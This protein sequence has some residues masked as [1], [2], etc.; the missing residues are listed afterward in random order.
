[1]RFIRLS[2]SCADSPQSHPRF[3]CAR[4]APAPRL[5]SLPKLPPR[6]RRRSFDVDAVGKRLDQNLA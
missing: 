2:A 6:L 4:G 5:T 3:A 1:M